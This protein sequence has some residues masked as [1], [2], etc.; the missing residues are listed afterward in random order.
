ME[1]TTAPGAK[2]SGRSTEGGQHSS[3]V[4]H[5]PPT[6]GCICVL[7]RKPLRHQFLEMLGSRGLE[8]DCH[9]TKLA[10]QQ[11]HLLG[12]MALTLKCELM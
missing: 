5:S 8:L 11:C 7:R 1:F 10:V 3:P 4:P 9:V 12:I 2:G 6:L